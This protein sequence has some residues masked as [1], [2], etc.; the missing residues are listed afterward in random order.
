ML[1]SDE[2]FQILC[3]EAQTAE[4]LTYV[5][6]FIEQHDNAECSLY[7]LANLIQSSKSLD[8]LKTTL[9]SERAKVSVIGLLRKASNLGARAYKERLVD[10]LC[11][12][13]IKILK[14]NSFR[15]FLK[16]NLV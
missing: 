3:G 16:E 1:L 2:D 15:M 13:D 7:L 10:H 11:E 8:H 14:S 9:Y 4:L 5:I 12:N 6:Q